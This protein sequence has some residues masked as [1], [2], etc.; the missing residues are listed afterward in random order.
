[1]EG[2]IRSLWAGLLSAACLGPRAL[3]A[4]DTAHAAVEPG[5]PPA[6]YG[7]LRQDDVGLE[8]RTATFAVRIVPLDE[9]VIRL[10]TPET[11]RSFA[12]LKRTREGEIREAAARAGISEPA[13][14]LVTFFGLQHQARFIPEELTIT[15]RNRIFR[16]AAIL[17]LSPRFS[18]LMLQQRETAAAIYLYQG[19][20]ALFEPLVVAYEGIVSEQW[21]RILPILDRERAAVQSRAATKPK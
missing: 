7:T 4:Q 6:G 16:P 11:Y 19:E 5:L 3:R 13:F 9:R 21:E 2:I 17:P 12:H 20:I 15:S 10:L 14:F 8:L 18:D 1:M